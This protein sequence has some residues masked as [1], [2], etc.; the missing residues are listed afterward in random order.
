MHHIA[1]RD[2]RDGIGGV[3]HPPPPE[4]NDVLRFIFIDAEKKKKKRLPPIPPPRH[5][6][7]ASKKS[8]VERREHTPVEVWGFFWVFFVFLKIQNRM[9]VTL[10][11]L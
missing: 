3:G 4:I 7:S 8:K 10:D 1:E 5:F 11:A 2:A 9:S 6:F